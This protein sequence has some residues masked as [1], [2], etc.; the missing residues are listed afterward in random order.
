MFGIDSFSIEETD[1]Q[2]KISQGHLFTRQMTC[3]QNEIFTFIA[4]LSLLA[5]YRC[6]FSKHST[7]E[8]QINFRTWLHVLF[9]QT[10]TGVSLQFSSGFLSC[11]FTQ[12]FPQNVPHQTACDYVKKT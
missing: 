2:L 8:R 3:S 12:D 1:Q 6:L 7:A 11:A 9:F 10:L 4:S 5:K